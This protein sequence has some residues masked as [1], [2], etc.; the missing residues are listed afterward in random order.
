ME[1]TERKAH[2]RPEQPK[3]MKSKT[4]IRTATA[5]A[6]ACSVLF[7]ITGCD[8]KP[9]WTIVIDPQGNYGYVNW[10]GRV[11]GEY[12]TCEEAQAARDKAKKWSDDF[13]ANMKKKRSR[14][15]YQKANCE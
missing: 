12:K 1:D 14:G 3:T 4:N 5:L 11:E 8:H 15:Y 2:A 10:E 7:C 9:N 13:D 6:V